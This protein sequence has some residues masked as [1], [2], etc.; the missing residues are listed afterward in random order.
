MLLKSFRVASSQLAALVLTVT[1]LTGCGGSSAS[2]E[3]PQTVTGPGFSFSAPADWQPAVGKRRASASHDDELV[4]VAAF[5]L[6][7]PYSDALFDRVDRELRARMRQI[8]GQTGGMITSSSTVTTGGIRSHSY[9]VT[10]GDHVD[11]YT[12]ALRGMR[13][14]QLLCRRASASSD[15]ACA[16]LITSFRPV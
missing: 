7:K 10:A 3:Q 15:A 9:E 1:I 12:F 6:L 2:N 13:E 4:Q 8:A 5:P 11:Q 16:Q 14:F